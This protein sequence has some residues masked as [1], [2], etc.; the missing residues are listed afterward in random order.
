MLQDDSNEL[1]I[2]KLRATAVRC[3][4]DFE[5]FAKTCLKIADKAGNLTPLLL[6]KEQRILHEKF[7]RQL[8]EKG[9]V[10]AIVL[11]GRQQGVSTY[12]EARF[13]WQL[14][15]VKAGRT[16]RVFI[17]T[18]K[19][20]ATE[21]LFN[22]AKRYHESMP[23]HLK[24]P[25][26]RSNAKELIF[27]DTGC[28]YGVATAGGVE[29]G[30]SLTLHYVHASEAGFWPNAEM[31]VTSLLNTALSGAPG[32]ESIIES[33][34]NGIGNV[35]HRYWQ[36]AAKGQSD[37]EAIFLPWFWHEEYVVE[38]PEDW[39]PPEEFMVYGQLYELTWEQ[40]YW[41]YLKNR[42]NAFVAGLPDDKFAPK[43]QQEYP[44]NADEA[45][46]T[47][48]ESFIPALAILKARK[49]EVKIQGTGPI[50]LGIDPARTGDLVGIIDRCGRRA[51]E[52]IS[53]RWEPGGNLVHLAERI[54]HIIDKIRPDAVCIDV[55]G[56][57]AGVYDNLLEWEYGRIL[58][59]VNFGSKPIGR[60]P[61]GQEMYF[62]RRAEMFDN[63][64]DWFNTEGG[65]QIPDDDSLQSDLTSMKVGPGATRYNN[66]NELIIEDKEKIKSR[67]GA[68]P[69]LADA[70]ALTFAVQYYHRA[71]ANYQ[72]SQSRRKT[73]RRTGY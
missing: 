23:A 12:V 5:F 6:N 30:R 48:G 11:K 16:L 18:H 68:S 24:P 4:N 65:V 2:E 55:G 69:D 26:T 58:H 72:P 40:L 13:Y 49:P 28:N 25:I 27:A 37:Y 42:E 51:G 22:M 33:T 1:D 59:P 36:A 10:R 7:E 43:T 70:L 19:D 67:L 14:W 64:R 34:A 21:N 9:R 29:I 56:N 44:A 60:G 32:T 45:F 39:N 63:L 73:N 35:Y 38:C 53:A 57:G 71:E 31:H 54:A 8:K 47:S 3:I 20:E 50:I 46:I 15:K 41:I 66:N 62:N 52:R 17:L 61:T